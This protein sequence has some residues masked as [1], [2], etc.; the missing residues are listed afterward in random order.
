VLP[1]FLVL[2]APRSATTSLH[3]YLGQHPQVAMSLTKEPNFFLF[4][5]SSGRATPM[6]DEPSI[7]AKSVSDPRD[8]ERLFPRA[9]PGAV[10][11]ASPLY[12]YTQGAP[13]LVADALSRPRLIA[14]LRE[15]VARAYSHF[16]YVYP[17]LGERTSAAFVDA[18]RTELPLADSPYRSGT[19]SLRLG[20]YAPQLSRWLDS[21]P[22]DQLLVLAFDDV[23]Q[24]TAPTLARVCRF[25]GVDAAYS[26]DTARRYAPSAAAG[27]GIG[28]RLLK[29]VRP[30][31]KRMLP[32][33]VAGSLA[34]R[35][36]GAQADRAQPPP[37]IPETVREL[38]RDYYAESNGW[39]EK[40]F[41]ITLAG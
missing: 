41:G 22:R 33:R 16:S 34:R 7:I 37:P 36:A 25:L 2:G 24:R 39:V 38:L 31:L 29:P 1:E 30:R 14:L 9:S 6:I 35:R 3:Y 12:L 20:R 11:E 21:F 18:V 28:E 13:A 19:H 10:G 23:Q 8:Y 26:F 40:E 27:R 15:P 4:D 17:G 32:P 5:R